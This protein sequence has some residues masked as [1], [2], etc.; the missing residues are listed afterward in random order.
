MTKKSSVIPIN[1]CPICKGKTPKRSLNPCA[2]ASKLCSIYEEIVRSYSEMMG[3]D[4][5]WINEAGI[6]GN[7]AY[8]TGGGVP[9]DNLSQLYPYPEKPGNKLQELGSIAED[10]CES[11]SSDLFHDLTDLEDEEANTNKL[12]LDGN[13]TS[14]IYDETTQ[15]DQD[16][17]QLTYARLAA[18][19]LPSSPLIYTVEETQLNCDRITINTQEWEKLEAINESIDRELEELEKKLATSVNNRIVE[20]LNKENSKHIV[21][22][23]N[24]KIPESKTSKVIIPKSSKVIGTVKSEPIP[25]LDIKAVK[26]NINYTEVVPEQPKKIKP[27]RTVSKAVTELLEHTTEDQKNK[28]TPRITVTPTV[29]PETP[30]SLDNFTTKIKVASGK[31]KKPK[32]DTSDSSNSILNTVPIS[33]STT[34]IKDEKS[35][36]QLTKFSDKF[37]FQILPD[38]QFTDFLIITTGPGFIVKKRTMKYF[39]AL[40]LKK[41]VISF[42]WIGACLKAGKILST[43]AY[44]I[45]GDEIGVQQKQKKCS[46]YSKLFSVYKIYMYGCFSQPPRDQLEKLIRLANCPIVENVSD[47]TR[48][49]VVLADPSSQFTF[50]KDAQVIKK[51][52]IVS[53]NW[54]L[55]SISVGEALDFHEYL[56]L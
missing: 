31:T 47:L 11:Q 51:Y 4:E 28:N 55:D 49:S 15:L 52:P 8:Y 24:I 41:E 46:D 2:A 40:I 16:L 6:R 30:L 29:K 20:G 27:V 25:I 43:T 21:N 19:T 33:F 12:Q 35:L 5:D 23:E 34:A 54:V 32:L 3:G 1:E 50:E 48:G 42:D 56:I 22:T 38:L 7:D 18:G 36:I 45:K 9:L 39:E 17:T 37:D 14:R 44:Q 53:P 10:N 26:K 13:E